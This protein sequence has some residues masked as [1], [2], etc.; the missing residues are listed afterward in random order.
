MTAPFADERSLMSAIAALGR[1]V[2]APHRA[3]DDLAR[4]VWAGL[5]EPGDGIAGMLID[6]LGAQEAL[7]VAQCA[8]PGAAP[9]PAIDLSPRDWA[10]A[11]ARWRPRLASASDPGNALRVAAARSIR[12]VMPGDADWPAP[13][14]DLG[15]HRPV[16]LWVRGDSRRL[17]GDGNPAVAIVGARAATGYGEHVAGELAAD[18]AGRGLTVVSGGAYGIDGTAHRAALAVGGTTIAVM[19]GGVDRAYPAGHTALF[20]EIAATGVVISE[21][22]CGGSP[23]KWRFLSRNRLIAALTGATVVVEAGVRSGSLN[24]A[25]HAATLGRPIGAV[26]GP[27]T[28][29]SSAGCHRLLREYD[30]RCIT[31]ARDIVELLDPGTLFDMGDGASA[32][33]AGVRPRTDDLM[34]VRDALSTRSRRDVDD[35]ARR[36]GMSL[37]EVETRLG[38]LLIAGEVDR[39]PD[40]WLLGATGTG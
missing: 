26:P 21:V 10:D 23:T 40:G 35:V 22:P 17:G 6:T 33:S 5:V 14:D 3:R 19:A 34:R 39:G 12:L 9:P 37:A 38:L 28:S 27:I 1:D 4:V 30:A 32:D 24:T 25:N 20:D 7:R 2:G 29:P 18:L 13:L 15:H 11:L 8:R 31:D 36:S 16:C